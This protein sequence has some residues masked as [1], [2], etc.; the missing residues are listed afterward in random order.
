MLKAISNKNVLAAQFELA[1]FDGDWLEHL[2]RP[3]L[4]GIWFVYGKSGS[5]KSTYCLSLAK[6]LCRFVFKVAY[7]S[8][9]Q[10]LSPSM[11]SAWRR[12]HMEECGN[13]IVLLHREGLSALRLRLKKQ[14]SPN[15]VFIDSVMYL[16]HDSAT[17]ILALRRDFPK[18]LFVLVGQEKDGD[19]ATSKQR[20]LKHD[21]DIKV[22]LIGGK[23]V[24][25]TR[26]ATEDGHGGR[27]LVVYTPR[28]R[29][30]D[31]D[32]INGAKDPEEEI[33]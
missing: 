19:A 17:D 12:C 2:G 13:R 20:R 6:Y 23:A 18:K 4:Q 27:P 21:A 32:F 24:C 29:R 14:H 31:G 15:V 26:Y 10:G 7:N 30:F 22:R 8:L 25:E 9:E 16:E 11:Q 5:G 28:K 1:A 33:V 3:A